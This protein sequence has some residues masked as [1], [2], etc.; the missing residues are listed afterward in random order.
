MIRSGFNMGLVSHVL[1]SAIMLF[2]ISILSMEWT[3]IKYLSSE[4]G[5][6]LSSFF[7]HIELS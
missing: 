2:S 3:R 1:A 4:K 7:H 5:I 6:A